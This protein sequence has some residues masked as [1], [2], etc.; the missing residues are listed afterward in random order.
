[1]SSS[2]KRDVC[3]VLLVQALRAHFALQRRRYKAKRL[4]KSALGAMP[5]FVMKPKDYFCES[6][7]RIRANAEPSA[8]LLFFEE[9]KMF[10]E[11][12]LKE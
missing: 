5:L 2:H 9:K 1:M 7:F 8:L 6:I 3:L 11:V 10:E 12:A 4:V